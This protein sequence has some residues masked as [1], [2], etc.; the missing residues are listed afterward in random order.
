MAVMYL[1]VVYFRNGEKGYWM[2]HRSTNPPTVKNINL[3]W[4]SDTYDGAK[5]EIEQMTPACPTLSFQIEKLFYYP[6]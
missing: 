2:G 4:G 6:A 5:E 3:A 1:V